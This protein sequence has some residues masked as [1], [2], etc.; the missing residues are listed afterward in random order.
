MEDIMER[1]NYVQILK[2]MKQNLE[3][4]ESEY[5]NFVQEFWNRII[6]QFFNLNLFFK[7][8]DPEGHKGYMTE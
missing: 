1:Q 2:Y 7:N 3:I 8:L 4:S 6:T 5:D